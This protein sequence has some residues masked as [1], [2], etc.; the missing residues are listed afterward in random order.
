MARAIIRLSI[1]SGDASVRTRNRVAN[2]LIRDHGFRSVGT[3]SYE[4][5]GAGTSELITALRVL[6]AKLSRP[7]AA[8]LDHLW[9]YIDNPEP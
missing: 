5:A 8:E 3:G 9:V 1:Q 4:R 2:A 7:D 6:L